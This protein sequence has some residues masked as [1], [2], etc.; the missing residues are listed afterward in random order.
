MAPAPSSGNKCLK[1]W[2][3]STSHAFRTRPSASFTSPPTT[4]RWTRYSMCDLCS[5]VSNYSSP[6]PSPS[7]FC[8]LL[9]TNWKLCVVHTTG[10]RIGQASECFVYWKDPMTNDT[11]GL[12]FTSPID[13][14]QF[15]ECCV[16]ILLQYVCCILC[17]RHNDDDKQPPQLIPQPPKKKKKEMRKPP[18]PP[19]TL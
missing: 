17:I 1:I 10:T 18:Q 16:S 15:R 19:T 4:V 13:A 6:S 14:K 5:Q 11:W 8:C 7:S 2:F 12:N 9:A 3:L